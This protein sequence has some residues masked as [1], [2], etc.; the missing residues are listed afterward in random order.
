MNILTIG[1]ATEDTFLNMSPPDFM[2]WTSN[3]STNYYMLFKAG[4]K[5]EVEDI[6]IT[7]GGGATNAATSFRRL[8][9]EVSCFAKIGKDSH[10]QTI[11]NELEQV[12]INCA[13]I[14][15]S[16]TE[17]TGRSIII[18]DQRG[19]RIIFA[20][21]G[22]NGTITK[23]ELPFAA[24]EHADALYITSLSHQSSHTLKTIVTHAAQHRK[25]IAINPGTSQLREG[26]P[27]LRETLPFFDTLI[28][29]SEEACTFMVTLIET[30]PTT[31]GPISCSELAATSPRDNAQQARLLA[32]PISYLHWHLDMRRFFE[33]ILNLGT[34]TVVVTDGSHGVYVAHDGAILFHPAV[35]TTVVDT[36]G[37]GDAF[38]SCFVA[39]RL[40][41]YSIAD[42]LHAGMINSTSVIEKIGA[43]AGLLDEKTLKKRMNEI[44]PM[45]EYFTI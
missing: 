45:I 25:L 35:P 9:F 24:I 30:E 27:D 31:C 43:K 34:K 14:I 15:F 26:A 42:A 41:G 21:R 19:E 44:P 1:G 8:G 5:F 39:T 4:N 16:P 40:L 6:F 22:A 29:N 38:G 13:H 23:Q 18:N 10:G 7:S 32:T 28:L 3:Q 20:Y 11:C 12:G 37:A 33:I 2:E 36:T 17:I